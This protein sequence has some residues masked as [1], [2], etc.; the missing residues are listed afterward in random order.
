MTR[1]N[2]VW[3]FLGVTFVL[4]LAWVTSAVYAYGGDPTLIHACVNKSSGEVKIVGPNASCQKNENPLEWP[5]TSALDK[6]SVIVHGTQQFAGFKVC[7]GIGGVCTYR[8]PRDGTIQNMRI[9]IESNSYNGP[10]V[11]TLVVNGNSTRLSTT[12]PAGSTSSI[13]VPGTVGILDGDRVSVQ[14]DATAASGGQ[15]GISVSYIIK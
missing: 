8:S 3:L 7:I 12:I 10:A 9:F 2:V 6:G 5:G 15:I 13:N 14:M 4:A 11:V 1:R